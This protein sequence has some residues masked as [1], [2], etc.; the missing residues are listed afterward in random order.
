[1][2]A[3]DWMIKNQ[4]RL[5]E[6]ARMSRTAGSRPDYVQGGGGNTSCKLDDRLMAI[7]ASGFRLDQVREDQAYAVLDYQALR[8]F[9]SHADPAGYADIEKEGS[10]RAG[11]AIQ[12]I[13]GLPQLRPSVETGF[14]SLLDIYV[15]HTHPVY[16]NLV[17][18]CS[19]GREVAAAA[20]AGLL[21]ETGET[22][23][24]VPYINPG[25]Q[26]TFAVDRARREAAAANGSGRLPRIL[27]MQNH[28]LII[29]ADDVD[30]CLDLQDRVND[31]L[32]AAFGLSRQDWPAVILEA[33]PVNLPDG[34]SGHHAA[35]ICWVSKTGWLRDQLLHASWDLDLFTRQALYP[36]QLVFLAGQMGAVETG[37]LDDALKTGWLPA[38]KCTIFRQTGEV[39]YACGANEARTIEETLCAILFITG[40]IGRKGLKVCTMSEAGQQFITGWESESYRKTVGAR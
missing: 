38:D 10:S 12:K 37:S 19:E 40:A 13:D 33:G 20:L 28:G 27:F 29:T 6:Y 32:A 2:M 17:T 24:F 9:Y 8:S 15:L 1:M 4:A 36:D 22:M 3:S 39:Y 31:A 25:T 35:T 11:A 34:V 21:A 7:K 14:H 5:S 30:T 16:A 23:A 18:C 26:L